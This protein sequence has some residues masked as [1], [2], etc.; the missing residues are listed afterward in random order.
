MA[1]V[2]EAFVSSVFSV[3]YKKFVCIRVNSWFLINDLFAV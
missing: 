3:D 1:D 2:C